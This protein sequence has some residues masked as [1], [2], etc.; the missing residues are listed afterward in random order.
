MIIIHIRFHFAS[1]FTPGG[2]VVASS[3]LVVP[4]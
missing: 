1:C 4:T 2:R 3:N